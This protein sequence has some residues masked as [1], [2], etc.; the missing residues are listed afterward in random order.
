[1]DLEEALQFAKL[2]S[3]ETGRSYLVRRVGDEYIVE[4]EDEGVATVEQES[5]SRT[6]LRRVWPR[7]A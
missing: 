3:R 2:L 1:M 5:N 6:F 7:R 4:L